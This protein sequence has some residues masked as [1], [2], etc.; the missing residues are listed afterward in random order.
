LFV[1]APQARAEYV[2]QT[3]TQTR[4]IPLTLTDWNEHTASLEG[5]NPFQ[6]QQFNAADYTAPG[7][8][9]SNVML[10]GV[11]VVLNYQFANTITMRFDTPS[12]INVTA[13]GEMHL[14]LPGVTD[15]LVGAPTL[16]TSAERTATPSD[17]FPKFVTLPTKYT[18]GTSSMG[19]THDA[20]PNVLAAFTGTG[21][22]Y[23]PVVA[24]AKSSFTSTSGN[25]RGT[26]D[27][28]ASATVS[29]IYFYTYVVPEPASVMLMGLGGGGLV[30]AYRARSRRRG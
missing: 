27:T 29:V 28:A 26:S 12:T 17:L 23:L 21:S 6:I 10:L 16:G 25:A 24:T 11:A 4:E 9:A 7:Q 20:N 3:A 2:I 8:S 22:I 13:S 1:I 18:S 5:K 14:K 19:Y 15:N 30:L